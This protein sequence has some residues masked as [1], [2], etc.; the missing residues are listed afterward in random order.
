M[1][2]VAV[3]VTTYFKHA[4]STVVSIVV[5]KIKCVFPS[6]GTVDVHELTHSTVID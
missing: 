2:C 4:L 5:L 1:F 3:L 6:D